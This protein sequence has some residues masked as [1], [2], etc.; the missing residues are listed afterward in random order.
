VQAQTAYSATKWHWEHVQAHGTDPLSPSVPDSANPGKTKANKLNDT[1]K[2]QYHDAF[3]QAERELHSAELAV[4]QAQ[5]AAESAH[6]AEIKG[7]QVAEASVTSA[8]ANLERTTSAV[9]SEQLAQARSQLAQARE[10]SA[11][12]RS[13]ARRSDRRGTGRRRCRR[14]KPGAD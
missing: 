11:V 10:F 9:L 4:Q 6:Q 3:V 14:G 5:V 12:A 2:Q 13:A 8:Q 7:L 1:Q